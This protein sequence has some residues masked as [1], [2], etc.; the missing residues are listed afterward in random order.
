MIHWIL[1]PIFAT[2][3]LQPP[4]PCGETFIVTQG[5]GGITSHTGKEQYAWDFGLPVGTPV[6]A[7]AAG[8][9]TRMREDSQEGGCS[10]SYGNDGNYVV[11]DH[12]D[13]TS[14]LYLHLMTDSVP[15]A[16]GDR[17]ESGEMIGRVG[18]TGFTCGAHL[19][20][21]IQDNCASWY[22]QSRAATFDVVGTPEEGQ[23][24]ARYECPTCDVELD[25][26]EQT[27]HEHD[28][29]CA[30]RVPDHW[31]SHDVGEGE[32]ALSV[33]VADLIPG[34]SEDDLPPAWRFSAR[35][36]NPHELEVYLPIVEGHSPA[37]RYRV[38]HDDG[39][40]DVEVN[41]AREAGWQGL[42]VYSFGRTEDPRVELVADADVVVDSAA[43]A[44]MDALRLRPVHMPADD[45][46]YDTPADASDDGWDGVSGARGT[47]D[48]GGCACRLQR[49]RAVPWGALGATF[50]FVVAAR[51]RRRD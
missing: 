9:I 27:V 42:G 1:L 29:S 11:I 32:H 17:V 38:V 49:R 22:C 39:I 31:D 18:L 16:V 3:L 8:T 7:A 35:N 51:R 2:P 50:V 45:A 15:F 30:G 23:L 13:G 12:G 24:M 34:D 28:L 26:E 37:V 10:S 36:A 41:L 40:D 20:L 14:A 48:V 25:G 33:P 5:N 47:D 4:W 6:V 46:P 44:T 21:Q 43:I 19:H